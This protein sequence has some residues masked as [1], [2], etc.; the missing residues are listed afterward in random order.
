MIG[1]PQ[2]HP[3]GKGAAP[4]DGLAAMER[5]IHLDIPKTAGNS[6]RAAM[7]RC[8][9]RRV[10]VYP[11]WQEENYHS[12]SPDDYDFYSGHI[13]FNTASRIGGRMVSV[14]RHPV[15]RFISVYYYWKHL[16]D[17]GAE[18]RQATI[19]AN[20]YSLEQFA[21]IR[22]VFALTE[23]LNNRMTLQVAYG[24]SE[25]HRELVRTRG[26][27]D[28]DI[29]QMAIENVAAFAVIGTQDNMADFGSRI[30]TRFNLDIPIDI[31]NQNEERV[32]REDVSFG[33]K[34]RILEWVYMD[35]ELYDHVQN[36]CRERDD[37]ARTAA[38]PVLVSLTA[39]ATP[40]APP[41]HA[42]PAEASAADGAVVPAS[43]LPAAAATRGKE[44]RKPA[45]P[46][47]P[48]KPMA[49]PEVVVAARSSARDQA[50]HRRVDKTRP[51]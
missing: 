14:F 1:Y 27:T 7:E 47:K 45:K 34:S 8:A 15:D 40:P 28:E 19:L 25:H 46:A 20:K 24:T 22:D 6:L 31:L 38:T 26:L 44:R 11:H 12:F 39:P 5:I 41:P 23:E 35:M 30:K 43:V 32:S 9:N 13:G 2:G 50:A 42:T 51:S 4:I 18:V 33:T 29:Y 48:A 37:A 21:R 17:T 49:E 3:Q 10:R 16:H 36:L